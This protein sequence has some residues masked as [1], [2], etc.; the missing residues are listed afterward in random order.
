MHVSLL[1][2][3]LCVCRTRHCCG[4]FRDEFTLTPFTAWQRCS[5]GVSGLVW[6]GTSSP[7]RAVAWRLGNSGLSMSDFHHAVSFRAGMTPTRRL[8]SSS[9]SLMQP[10]AATAPP[11]PSTST[12]TGSRPRTTWISCRSLWVSENKGPGVVS[13]RPGSTGRS[14][15]KWSH[16]LCR[17]SAS[18]A[19][20]ACL[21]VLS[22]VALF[23]PC[24]L[25][26]H[27]SRRLLRHHAS[28]P[29]LDGQPS[30][31]GRAHTRD[32]GLRQQ[33]RRTRYRSAGKRAATSAAP[34]QQL[35]L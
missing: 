13:G 12:S 3:L 24:R 14:G 9:R 15:R 32:P 34:A 7:G 16:G 35:S 20:S 30:G 10:T 26:P 1:L 31:Q 25:R 18:H 6:S 11:C 23:C 22:T 29:R 8:T 2:G 4:R 27:V 17:C 28:A 19:A 5:L 33:G 21:Q